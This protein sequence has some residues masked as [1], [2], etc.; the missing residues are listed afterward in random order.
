MALQYSTLCIT[1]ISNAGLPKFVRF[2]KNVWGIEQGGK[3]D[4]K[5]A[6]AGIDA[7]ADFIKEIG[8]P[9][10]LKELGVKKTQ[11]KEIAYSCG[12]SQGSY[13]KMTH[14]EILEI[15]KQCYE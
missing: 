11:L 6:L 9:T 1:A 3:T 7:L 13:K 8:L 14:K 15:L 2:A 5:L 4:D 12:I 10:T